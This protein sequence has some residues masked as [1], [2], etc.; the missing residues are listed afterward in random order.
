M[1]K[2]G[3]WWA[4]APGQVLLALM[5]LIALSV[6]LTSPRVLLSEQAW[7]QSIDPSSE[8]TKSSS[9]SLDWK[10]EP[11]GDT[12]APRDAPFRKLLNQPAANLS[13]FERYGEFFIGE[14]LFNRRWFF[15]TQSGNQKSDGLGPLFN[16]NS[17]LGCHVNGGRGHVPSGRGPTEASPAVIKIA[18][19]W[20]SSQSLGRFPLPRQEPHPYYGFQIQDHAVPQVRAEGDIKLS[21][22]YEKRA[23]TLLRKPHIRVENLG[24]G[25]LD[26]ERVALSLRVAPAITG[27]GLVEAIDEE[28]ILSWADPFDTD[29]DGISG[30]ASWVPTVG[31]YGHGGRGHDLRL[32]RF[33]WKALHP[34][35]K[36]Q[37]LEAFFID[38]GMNSPQ[39]RDSFGDCRIRQKSCVF[40]ALVDTK[41]DFEARQRRKPMTIQTRPITQE[42]NNWDVDQNAIDMTVYYTQ[43]LAPLKRQRSS[44]QDQEGPKQKRDRQKGGQLFLSLGCAGCHRPSYVTGDDHPR[45]ILREQRIYPFSD[46]LLHDLGPGLDDGLERPH[47]RSSE[48]RTA[49]LWGLGVVQKV[50][51]EAGF[52]HDGRA[53]TVREAI[54]WHGGEARDARQ[55]FEDLSEEQEKALMEFLWSL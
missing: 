24:Y 34:S 10:A 18:Y 4:Q 45:K 46:F 21:F 20:L 22:S 49:P 32:G 29:G 27:L 17:C 1:I 2:A 28:D 31:Y 3:S 8:D 11:G 53:R 52:L 7:G 25:P 16:A 44:S 41:R 50:N 15:S 37:N 47:S 38:M 40:E 9:L 5:F 55:R 33:G 6:F 35:L 19:S 26:E 13:H 48:W 23:G 12:S 30:R 14:N 36:A 39:H 42:S 54:L 43:V 51:P